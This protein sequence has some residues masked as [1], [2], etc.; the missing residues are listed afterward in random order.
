MALGIFVLGW[1]LRAAQYSR[2]QALQR[3]FA[4]QVIASQEAERKRIAAELH[5]GLGQ[6]LAV[7]KNMALLL[8]R[9]A[10]GDYEER[11]EA[12]AAETSQV[13]SDVRQIS[14][15]LRP[16]QLDLLGLS[17]AIQVLAA[18]TCEAA[19]IR[20]DVVVD[21]LSGAFQREAEIHLYRVVQECLSNIVKH[22]KASAIT[23][24]VKR[25]AT[26]VS[27]VIRDDGVG[28]VPVN[29]NGEG[30]AGGFGLTGISERAQ[31]LGGRATIHSVPGQ[32]TTIAIEIDLKA[33]A[34]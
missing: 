18:G 9:S 2:R 31:L 24:L 8:N 16:Y 32:G 27:L 6:R 25:T 3:A 28:F 33:Y 4:Q 21:D 29:L 1:R 26:A 19:G 11:V 15:N 34:R 30:K 23:E 20:A 17:K 22:A 10:Y 7:I 13:I 5:D 14:R 12:I